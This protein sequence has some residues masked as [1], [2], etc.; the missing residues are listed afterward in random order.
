MTY[1]HPYEI[2][3][4]FP[5]D[6]PMSL[7]RRFRHGFRNGRI[8]SRLRKLFSDFEPMPVRDYLERAGFKV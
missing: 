4:H 2:G 7:T 1:L 6:L 8:E 3:G 5:R